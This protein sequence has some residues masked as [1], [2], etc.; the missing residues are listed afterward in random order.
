MTSGSGCYSGLESRRAAEQQD[1]TRISKAITRISRICSE[2]GAVG[3]IATSRFERVNDL[4]R[5]TYHGTSQIKERPDWV[6]GRVD[7][8]GTIRE[9]RVIVFNPR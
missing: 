4:G 6:I 8:L 7:A 9:I 1:L 2:A 3:V 5:M